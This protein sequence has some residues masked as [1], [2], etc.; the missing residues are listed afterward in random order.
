MP[1]GGSYKK[2]KDTHSLGR[3]LTSVEIRLDRGGAQSLRRESSNW[4][5]NSKT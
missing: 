3:P 5:V 4:F 2:R 1:W